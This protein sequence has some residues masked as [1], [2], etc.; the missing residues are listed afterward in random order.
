MTCAHIVLSAL[1]L[2]DLPLQATPDA[3]YLDFPFLRS[4]IITAHVVWWWPQ[5]LPK[6]R[7]SNDIAILQLDNDL[8][9]EAYPVR[10]N[11][12]PHIT[13]H[14]FRAY[15]FPENWDLSGGVNAYR[16]I[17]DK[18]TISSKFRVIRRSV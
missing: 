10:F 17:R 8:P 1:N 12:H 15:G 7:D 4:E 6:S 16:I 9:P 13:G 14:S 3:L 18:T 11:L 5:M 2:P